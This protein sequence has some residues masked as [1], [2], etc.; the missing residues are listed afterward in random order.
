MVNLEENL[1][2][3]SSPVDRI[4]QFPESFY[5]GRGRDG[6]L[7]LVSPALGGEEGTFDQDEPDPAPGPLL[8][9]PDQTVR[10]ETFF[11]GIVHGHL[12]HDQ[13]VF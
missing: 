6:Q 1:G 8:V 2:G 4:G 7:V 12:G 9:I 10:D 3:F 5:V 11:R 13:A